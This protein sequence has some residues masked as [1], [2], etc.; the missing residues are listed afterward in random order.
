MH[1][2]YERIEQIAGNV[3]VIEAD[4][5]VFAAPVHGFGTA[6]LMQTFI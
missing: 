5:I 6:S 1:K 3:I 4:G 2:V